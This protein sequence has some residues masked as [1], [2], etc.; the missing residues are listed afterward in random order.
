MQTELSTRIVE[1]R[2]GIRNPVLFRGWYRTFLSSIASKTAGWDKPTIEWLS[3]AFLSNDRSEQ[4]NIKISKELVE[5]IQRYCEIH[6]VF[7]PECNVAMGVEAEFMTSVLIR[8]VP[9]VTA[10]NF[11]FLMWGF[12]FSP[13]TV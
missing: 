7:L 8:N 13:L 2:S 1:V 9:S 11:R 6:S 3:E 5:N 10:L 12:N 4:R